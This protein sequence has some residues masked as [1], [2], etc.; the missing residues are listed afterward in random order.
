MNIYQSIK[1]FGKKVLLVSGLVA[2]LSGCD[3]GQRGTSQIV[4]DF[5]N[6]KKSDMVS[7][8]FEKG[9]RPKTKGYV[10][11]F[12]AYISLGRADGVYSQPQKTFHFELRPENLL[13][14]DINGDGNKDLLF[15]AFEKGKR[16]KT[17]GYVGSFDQFVALGNGDG[18]FQNPKKILHYDAKPEY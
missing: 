7:V 14:G 13:V 15:V 18:S 2:V 9:K 5:N 12:D 6:D 4:D 16:P 10:G 1:D 3:S 17:K 8:T 11:S